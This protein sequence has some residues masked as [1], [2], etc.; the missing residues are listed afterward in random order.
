MAGTRVGC[1]ANSTLIRSPA[2]LYVPENLRCF[3]NQLT[4]SNAGQSISL[5]EC[6]VQWPSEARLTLALPL[7]TTPLV[8]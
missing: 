7:K 6:F 5:A 3:V 2:P 1:Q 8:Q 4:T